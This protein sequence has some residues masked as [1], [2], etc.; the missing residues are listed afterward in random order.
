M[1]FEKVLFV[2]LILLVIFATGYV[3]GYIKGRNYR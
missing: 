2:A 3:L 1:E